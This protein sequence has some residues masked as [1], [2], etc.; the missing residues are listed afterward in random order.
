[1]LILFI[2]LILL[3]LICLIGAF[4]S[5]YETESIPLFFLILFAGLVSWVGASSIAA[6]EENMVREY[7]VASVEVYESC[8]NEEHK[9]YKFLISQ[10]DN[11]YI[12]IFLTEEKVELYYRDD[13]FYISNNELKKLV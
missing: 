9:V 3:G 1:M 2:I 13:K 7:N 12:Q 6:Q 5:L 8:N 4:A 11:T 10:E